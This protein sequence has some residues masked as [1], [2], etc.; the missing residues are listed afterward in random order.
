MKNINIDEKLNLKTGYSPKRK[1]E[2]KDAILL[3]KFQINI[4]HPY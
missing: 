1:Q 2:K 4:C 3:S